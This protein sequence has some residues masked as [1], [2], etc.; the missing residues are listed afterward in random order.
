[1]VL[2]FLCND[3]SCGTSWPA[4]YEDCANPPML[5]CLSSSHERVVSSKH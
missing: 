3:A 4:L 2:V 1:M 5:S